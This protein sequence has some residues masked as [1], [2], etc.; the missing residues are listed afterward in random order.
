VDKAASDFHLW[1][2]LRNCKNTKK[3]ISPFRRVSAILSVVA[4]WQHYCSKGLFSIN[5]QKKKGVKT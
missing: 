1:F 3:S 2:L 4:L 5:N